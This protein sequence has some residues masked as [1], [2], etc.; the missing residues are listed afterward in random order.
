MPA[1]VYIAIPAKGQVQSAPATIIH[2]ARHAH[3]V[4]GQTIARFFSVVVVDFK[5]NT[6]VVYSVKENELLYEAWSTVW[7]F[8]A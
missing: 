7:S 1:F 3:Q 4:F 8:K 2:G 5:G 6:M